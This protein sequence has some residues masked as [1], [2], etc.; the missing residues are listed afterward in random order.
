MSS[1]SENLRHIFAEQLLSIDNRL[2]A[3]VDDD[4]MLAGIQDTI[5]GLL[6]DDDGGENEIRRIVRER[7]RSG[8]LQRETYQL[9]ESMLDRFVAENIPTDP[10]SEVFMETPADEG[11]YEKTTALPHDVFDASVQNTNVDFDLGDDTS[12]KVTDAIGEPDEFD[13]DEYFRSTTVIP[14]DKLPDTKKT[15]RAQVGSLLRDRF[16]LHEQVSG[17]SMGVVYKAMDRRLAE[18][19][20]DTYWVAI[21]VLSPQLAENA[22]ALRALQQEAAKGRCLIHPNIVRCIDLDRDGDLFFIVM[23]WLEGR[24]LADILDS[25]D[26]KLIDREASL[27]IVRQ[28]GDALD[29]AHR[30]GIVHADIKPGNIMMMPDGDAKLF[31]FGVARVEQNQ[32]DA[33]FDPGVLGALTPAYSSM[34]VLTGEEPVVSDDVFSLGCLMYRLLAGYRVFGPRNAAEAAQEGMEPQRLKSLSD[35]QWRALKKALSY[36]RVTRFQSVGEFLD[37]FD[38]HSEATISFPDA[39]NPLDFAEPRS[40]K[41]W[42]ILTGLLLLAGA[43]FGAWKLGYLDSW[44]DESGGRGVVVRDNVRPEVSNSGHSAEEIEAQTTEPIQSE[45]DQSTPATGAAVDDSGT[46]ILTDA[47]IDSD[48]IVGPETPL[49]DFSTLPPADLIVPISEAGPAVELVTLTLLED[50]APVVVEF[51]RDGDLSTA[52]TAKVEEVGFSGNRSPWG[53]GQYA[54]SDEGLVEFLV[55]QER[56]RIIL[57][58]AS[59]VVREADQLSTLRVRDRELA[60]SELALIQVSLQDDDRRVYEANLPANTIAFSVAAVVVSESDP[61]V[62]IDVV[63]FSPDDSALSVP[64]SISDVTATD[65][66]DYFAPGNALISFGPRQRSARILV[67]LVQDPEVEGSEAFAVELFAEN[68]AAEPDL[69]RRVV[70]T[71]RDDDSEF[72]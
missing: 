22:Q 26:S 1:N 43:G 31:D 25:D 55:G 21:K 41:G 17:G 65:G 34:Q 70:V 45:P 33:S 56:G 35:T 39:D 24:T 54:L 57:S 44:I 47:E 38:S 23:E 32:R 58:M 61:A 68:S 69:N 67:P 16:L 62:Q 36:S 7:Y 27:R 20:G 60:D 15:T 46:D 19:G 11:A 66:A 14:K 63:R 28:I 72:R 2:R 13:E 59:D 3:T 53:T 9:V 8:M 50:S 6:A 51:L 37:K 12:V 48:D 4:D 18:V 5:S 64:Y 10:F 71:I 40:S 30:C 42:L 49:V 52:F 29:Y